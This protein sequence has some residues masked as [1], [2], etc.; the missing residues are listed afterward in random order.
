[1]TGLRS[2]KDS[3]E[4]YVFSGITYTFL[5]ISEQTLLH[6]L[7][8]DTLADLLCTRGLI[9]LIYHLQSVCFT[10]VVYTLQPP[11]HLVG[12]GG[13]VV[14]VSVLGHRGSTHG[15]V[16]VVMRMQARVKQFEM[17]LQPPGLA[18]AVAV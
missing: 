5:E 13:V 4:Q 14:M 10:V 6:P 12:H 7:L 9:F 18:V 3:I 16:L 15:S 1:M 2:I 17:G 8:D 11:T